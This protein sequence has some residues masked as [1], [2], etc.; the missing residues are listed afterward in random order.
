M[1]EEKKY[2]YIDNVFINDER[3]NVSE[4]GIL[5][6]IVTNNKTKYTFNSIQTQ[7]TSGI[8]KLKYFNGIK[9]LKECGYLD[10]K[11]LFGAGIHW[12]IKD[13]LK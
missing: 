6:N 10:S 12:V 4:I 9:K 5:L 1:N 8:P 2:Y 11:C 3:L 7:K 13:I